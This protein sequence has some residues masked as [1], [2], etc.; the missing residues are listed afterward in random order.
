MIFTIVEELRLV[1]KTRVFSKITVEVGE[2][3]ST[4]AAK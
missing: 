2:D 4:I 3:T 1:S